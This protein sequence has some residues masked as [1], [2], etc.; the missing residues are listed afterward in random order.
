MHFSKKIIIL[1]HFSERDLRDTDEYKAALRAALD[2]VN[3]PYCGAGRAKDAVNK[4]DSCAGR[5]RTNTV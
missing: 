4:P 1:V 2:A 3:N 5:G